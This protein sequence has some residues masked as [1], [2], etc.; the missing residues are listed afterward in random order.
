VNTETRRRN[1]TLPR[2]AR[3]LSAGYL[4]VVALIT[5]SPAPM[6]SGTSNTI[7]TVLAWLH[8]HG[9]PVW[10][11]YELL[12]FT[13]NIALF[14][15]LGL[16]GVVLVGVDRWW[17]TVVAGFL[18]SSVIEL[19]QLLFLPSRF[20]TLYDVLANTTGA[21]LGALLAVLAYDAAASRKR[22]RNA[23]TA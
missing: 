19:S 6:D 8:A 5:L 10:V 16:L 3:W 12:E 11:N 15:P 23:A 14:L 4:L 20:P 7:A 22:T 18:L 13:A 2:V 9:V 1:A 21:V 17:L